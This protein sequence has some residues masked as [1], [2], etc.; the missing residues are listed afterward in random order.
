MLGQYFTLSTELTMTGRQQ[1]LLTVPQQFSDF[2]LLDFA[3][4]PLLEWVVC[5]RIAPKMHN[6]V[7]KQPF[8]Q[9]DV[10]DSVGNLPLSAPISRSL[11]QG[12][13]LYIASGISSGKAIS[14]LR[15]GVTIEIDCAV[16]IC[17]SLNSHVFEILPLEHDRRL[18][19]Q[20]QVLN[21][22]R[23]IL[24]QVPDYNAGAVELAVQLSE[25][26]LT[27]RQLKRYQQRMALE[28]S[29]EAADELLQLLE[30]LEQKQQWL[31]HCYN[32]ALNRHSYRY[33]ANQI[34]DERLLRMLECYESLAPP[35]LVAMVAALT[36]DE[37]EH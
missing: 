12:F 7:R 25:I 30:H 6:L 1:L 18:I 17:F 32:Q 29:A 37:S 33:S 13:R 16:D 5:E 10:L 8:L 4:Y 27:N 35:E 22:A 20:P 28:L 26:L 9:L 2:V 15:Q 3:S 21:R 14:T 19:Q 31:G 23:D 11:G 34:A 36:G 24:A